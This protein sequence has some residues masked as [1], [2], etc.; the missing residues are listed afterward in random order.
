MGGWFSGVWLWLL[1]RLGAPAPA[2]EVV[3]PV[4]V[5]Q[6]GNRSFAAQPGTRGFLAQR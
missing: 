6:A 1:G 5:V 3:D 4:F 2:A